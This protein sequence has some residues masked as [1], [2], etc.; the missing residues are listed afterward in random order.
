[1]KSLVLL[2][3]LQLLDARSLAFAALAFLPACGSRGVQESAASGYVRMKVGPLSA[4]LIA[5]FEA[6]AELDALR[7]KP[8]EDVPVIFQFYRAAFQHMTILSD[9]RPFRYRRTRLS[10]GLTWVPLDDLQFLASGEVLAIQLDK[11]DPV[12]LS[13]TDARELRRFADRLAY[14]HTRLE[15]QNRGNETASPAR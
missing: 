11:D 13:P 14:H 4:G 3:S 1:M 12:V 9:G 6:R 8:A 5:S 15:L 10:E 2:R 7:L